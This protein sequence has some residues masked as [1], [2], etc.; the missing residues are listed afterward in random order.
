[1][2]FHKFH[3]I[4]YTVKFFLAEWVKEKL[5]PLQPINFWSEFSATLLVPFV[6]LDTPTE[7]YQKSGTVRFA[8]W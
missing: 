4:K 3:I 6:V 5:Y 7:G 8:I 2:T 1:M